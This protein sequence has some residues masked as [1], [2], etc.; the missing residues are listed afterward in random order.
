MA[1]W[2]CDAPFSL[3]LLS[4]MLIV[5]GSSHTLSSKLIANSLAFSSKYRRSPLWNCTYSI[6]TPSP[7]ISPLLMHSYS[8]VLHIFSFIDSIAHRPPVRLIDACLRLRRTPSVL[9][10]WA[11]KLVLSTRTLFLALIGSAQWSTPDFWGRGPHLASSSDMA[12][13]ASQIYW[14]HYRDASPGN[15]TSLA[16]FNTTGGGNSLFAR[17]TNEPN[18]NGYI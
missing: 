12:C 9:H 3:V 8:D 13:A 11:A 15:A 4:T 6:F 2:N 10:S 16:H 5:G 18:G 7:G 14:H 17:T 1:T